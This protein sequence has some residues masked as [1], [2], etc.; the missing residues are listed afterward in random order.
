MSPVHVGSELQVWRGPQIPKGARGGLPPETWLY[1]NSGGPLVQDRS[2]GL[3]LWKFYTCANLSGSI[4]SDA[5]KD[6][7]APALLIEDDAHSRLASS[8]K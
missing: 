4:P 2:P 7:S 1:P 3:I 5:P 6:C 8:L